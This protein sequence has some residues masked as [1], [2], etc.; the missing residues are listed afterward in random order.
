MTQQDN[1]ILSE[2]M[3]E[4]KESLS[5]KLRQIIYQTVLKIFGK[6]LPDFQFY[7]VK[8]EHPKIE[9][10][11][12]YSTN[13]AFILA[14]KL[15]LPPKAIGEAICL[16]INNNIKKH[17]TRSP[18][19]YNKIPSDMD[20][21]MYHILD[22]CNIAGSGFLNMW[23]SYS[24]LITLT[25]RLLKGENAVKS[26]Q[27]DKTFPP[28]LK[29][30]KIMVEYTDPNPFKEFHLGHLYSNTV[31]ESLSRLFEALGAAV[32]RADYFG[33][34]GMHV[35]KSIW[36]MRELMLREKIG[37]L[38]L[39]KRPIPARV[40]FLGQAYSLGVRVYEE[41]EKIK[42]QIKD[43]NYLV[44]I[45]AQEYLKEKYGWEPQIDYD[46]YIKEKKEQ[47]VQVKE[48]YFA[49]R[50]WSMGY[51]KQ[52]FARFGTK[53]DYY[54]PESIVGEIGVKI[55]REG[56]KKKIFEESEKAIVFRGESYGYHT[57]VF[58][59]ALGLP[60]Y[61]AKELGLAHLKYQHFPYD[62][63]INVVGTEI[64]EYFQVVM[65]ALS[66]INSKLWQKTRP[67]YTGMVKLPE[68]KMSSRTGN[69]VTAEMLLEEIKKRIYIVLQQNNI[70]YKKEYQEKIAEKAAIAAIKYSLLRIGLPGDI[71]FDL[72][73]SVSFH[74]ESGPYLMYTYT[75]CKSV[76][77]K[78]QNNETMKQCYNVS[79]SKNLQPNPEEMILLRSLYRF[80][81]VVVEA[82]RNY[83]PNLVCSY[84]FDLAAKYNLFYDKHSI[85]NPRI[86]NQESRIKNSESGGEILASEKS[87]FRLWLTEVTA[88]VLKKGLYLLGIETVEKM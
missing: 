59:N 35:A 57:R 82:A 66:L 42:E 23:L 71:V 65:T 52:I 38:E 11:G 60:T 27:N 18:I 69:V 32:K 49:G 5:F 77:R 85:L 79:N 47:L 61:E 26:T 63:S 81:E 75:R 86:K 56:L 7:E 48:L 14:S 83:S 28:V 1:N 80:S 21:D 30:R 10:Y 45:A 46:Q 39:S 25:S 43:I 34:V 50:S 44:Y 12:D 62:L 78:A 68:G 19:T 72:E 8:L 70:N 29:G 76:L 73:K 74:G 6:D 33:D 84:L 3:K 24:F 16:E 41:D 15:K 37:L 4:D 55:V 64:Y 40:K 20:K 67:L 9:N 31:G 2:L 36:G 13:I 54:F 58:L 51:F 53:F 88:A 22:R 17:Q 87:I